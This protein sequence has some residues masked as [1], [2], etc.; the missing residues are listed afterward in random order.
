MSETFSFIKE[1][2]PFF[3]STVN[4]DAPA[5]RP[6]GGMMEYNGSLYVATSTQKDVYRQLKA[7]PNVQIVSL[8]AQ[9]KAWI[10]VDGKA[11]EV[12]DLDSKQAMLDACPP[13]LKNFPTKEEPTLALF[14]ITEMTA[15]LYAG[16]QV[17]QLV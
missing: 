7:N 17:R 12:F 10:R 14:Q 8:K 16:G 5:V 6:F 9:E 1:C 4:G 3:I 11:I 15:K 2:G 13:L